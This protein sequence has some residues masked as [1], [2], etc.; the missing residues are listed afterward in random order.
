MYRQSASCPSR[1]SRAMRLPRWEPK[2]LWRQP[3]SMRIRPSSILPACGAFSL[4]G[5]ET[6]LPIFSQSLYWAGRKHDAEA[7]QTRDQLR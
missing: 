5:P 4:R 6:A 2:P 3:K 7:S 1:S